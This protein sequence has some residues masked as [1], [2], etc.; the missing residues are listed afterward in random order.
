MCFPHHEIIHFAFRTEEK[1]FAARYEAVYNH[2]PEMLQSDEYSKMRG[3][4][5][6]LDVLQS[7]AY[8]I[9]KKPLHMSRHAILAAKVCTY[10]SS[11]RVCFFLVIVFCLLIFRFYSVMLMDKSVC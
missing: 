5:H 3:L 11:L 4:P 10:L 1:E 9:N 7:E 2:F 6:G 8:T